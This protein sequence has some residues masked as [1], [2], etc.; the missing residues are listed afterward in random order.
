MS[1]FSTSPTRNHVEHRL[2]GST[3]EFVPKLIKTPM[4]NFGGAYGA[5]ATIKNWE[6]TVTVTYD[7]SAAPPFYAASQS[8]Y[9]PKQIAINKRLKIH[10]HIRKR[11]SATWSGCPFWKQRLVVVYWFFHNATLWLMDFRCLCRYVSPQQGIMPPFCNQ[12]SHVS[13]KCQVNQK[14]KTTHLWKHQ[15]QHPHL[16]FRRTLWMKPKMP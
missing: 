10:Q 12:G 1:R 16:D 4:C 2:V 7:T 15:L 6:W 5:H 11:F 3:R 14:I 13:S 9:Y 8:F